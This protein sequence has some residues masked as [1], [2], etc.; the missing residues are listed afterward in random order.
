MGFCRQN[1]HLSEMAKMEA[2]TGRTAITT[3]AS[4]FMSALRNYSAEAR[5]G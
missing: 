1:I 4:G 2:R 5:P 3:C